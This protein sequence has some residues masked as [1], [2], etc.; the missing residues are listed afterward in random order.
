MDGHDVNAVRE[1]CVFGSYRNDDGC[2]CAKY[3]MAVLLGCVLR[4]QSML[5]GGAGFVA[6]SSSCGRNWGLCRLCMLS[7]TWRCSLEPGAASAE[8]SLAVES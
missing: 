4:H 7:M 5:G 6:G 3:A 1:S 8:P 2:H